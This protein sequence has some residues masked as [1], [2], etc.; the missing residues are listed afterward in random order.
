MES[1]LFINFSYKVSITHQHDQQH[2]DWQLPDWAKVVSKQKD[3]IS[4]SLIN[5]FLCKIRTNLK[6][7]ISVGYH[8]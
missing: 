3:D 5:E 1:N 6:K 4:N 7:G 2:Q 8:K